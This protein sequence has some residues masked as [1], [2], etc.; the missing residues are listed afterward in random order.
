MLQQRRLLMEE[1]E[2]RTQVALENQVAKADA[3]CAAAEQQKLDLDCKIA[4]L[5]CL[6][7]HATGVK[8][9][10]EWKERLAASLQKACEQMLSAMEVQDD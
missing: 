7:D 6:L 4:R 3:R 1:E 5:R 9:L 8:F 2:E 10:L